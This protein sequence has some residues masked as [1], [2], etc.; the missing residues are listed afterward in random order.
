MLLFGLSL[1]IIQLHPGFQFHQHFMS[2]F[3]IRKLY[4]KFFCTW[5]LASYFFGARKF[6]EKLLFKCW[7]N[8]LHMSISPKC[9]NLLHFKKFSFTKKVQIETRNTVMYGAHFSHEKA[10]LQLLVKLSFPSQI[11]L[12][13]FD[14]LIEMCFFSTDSCFFRVEIPNEILF[15]TSSILCRHIKYA[16]PS[17]PS[18]FSGEGVRNPWTCNPTVCARNRGLHKQRN[19]TTN[20]II[21]FLS[22]LSWEF[23][24]NLRPE[25]IRWRAFVFPGVH[26]FYFIRATIPSTLR[27]ITL[28]FAN[29]DYVGFEFNF[30]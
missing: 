11:W 26:F 18:A 13:Y 19:Q 27:S 20:L 30:K 25:P 12:L 8:W 1:L 2:S 21:F 24:K 22:G 28:N 6:A 16:W 23:T 15:P 9:C 29:D 7:W 17:F 10:A 4:V 14:K 3:F 5:N